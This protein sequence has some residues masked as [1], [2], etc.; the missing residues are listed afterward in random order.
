MALRARPEAADL[1]VGL[2]RLHPAG[3]VAP[4]DVAGR[5]GDALQRAQPEAHHRQRQQ[6]QEQED[7]G[8]RGELD[9]HQPVQR[10]LDLGGG[11][12]DEEGAAVAGGGG[13]YPVADVA[14]L[15]RHGGE[16]LAVLGSVRQ[17]RDRPGGLL[18]TERRSRR[19]AQLPE[20]A[21][22]DHRPARRQPA[23]EALALGQLVVDRRP[24]VGEL[25]V[26]P[27]AQVVRQGLVDPGAAGRQPP[28]G[29]GQQA[30]HEAGPERPQRP[31]GPQRQ[32]GG[33]RV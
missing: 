25:G 28:D 2:G 23:G 9:P 17:V 18:V 14:V 22:G 7:G 8:G 26:E 19:A 32:A 1:G 3:E 24:A 33:R 10:L 13:Q 31:G 4:G 29:E 5:G 15:R 30:G 11:E 20:R 16:A 21:A 12:G 27:V 6:G